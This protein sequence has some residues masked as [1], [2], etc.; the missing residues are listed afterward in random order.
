M[1][2]MDRKITWDNLNTVRLHIQDTE[3][4]K[5]LAADKEMAE[6][7]CTINYHHH[8]AAGTDHQSAFMISF[9]IWQQ[10]QA[11]RLSNLT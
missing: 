2:H 1:E 4:S 9:T 10:D 5:W 8:Y 7:L 6:L 3:M 11:I